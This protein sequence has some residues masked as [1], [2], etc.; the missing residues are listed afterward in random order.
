MTLADLSDAAKLAVALLASFGTL[1]AAITLAYMVWKRA[2][3]EAE[4]VVSETWKRI[5]E[6]YEAEVKQLRCDVDELRA[7]LA[8]TR[9]AID[10]YGCE[11]APICPQRTPRRRVALHGIV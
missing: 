9:E 7:E 1:A 8:D 11:D 10:T 3:F 4:R 5:A 6:G 2:L